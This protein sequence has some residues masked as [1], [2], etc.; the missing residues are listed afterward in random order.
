MMNKQIIRG[1]LLPI[2]ALTLF[3]TCIGCEDDP[4][5][6]PNDGNSQGGSYGRI[7]IALPDDSSASKTVSRTVKADHNNN[8]AMF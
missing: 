2:A 6:Q 5:L 4:I 7:D 3:A 8:P 1:F